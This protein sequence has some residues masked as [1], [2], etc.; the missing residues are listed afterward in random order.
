MQLDNPLSCGIGI[1]N[2]PLSQ[3]DGRGARE[4][5]DSLGQGWLLRGPWEQIP[6]GLTCPA[7]PP[8]GP[9]APGTSV[10]P[11]LLVTGTLVHTSSAP[12]H[13]DNDRARGSSPQKKT[14]GGLGTP[15]ATDVS[16]TPDRRILPPNRRGWPS[17]APPRSSQPAPPPL[18]RGSRPPSPRTPAHLAE[19]L[20]DLLHLLVS[21]EEI[22]QGF[23][24]RVQVGQGLLLLQDQLLDGL[25]GDRLL[26]LFILWWE[27]QGAQRWSPQLLDLVSGASR[28]VGCSS[29]LICGPPRTSAFG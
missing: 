5:P 4:L 20:Q 28:G 21:P 13:S 8:H 14:Q 1:G 29:S 12:L 24:H 25:V 7:S 6:G 18:P 27:T 11:S 3:G 9:S 16:V 17:R 2:Y 15:R 23:L 26:P 22:G 10:P 19:A